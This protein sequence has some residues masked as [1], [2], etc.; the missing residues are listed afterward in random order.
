MEIPTP[1]PPITHPPHVKVCG[2][3]RFADVALA[4][5]LGASFLGL[6][7]AR[8]SKRRIDPAAAKDLVTRCRGELG[9]GLRFVGVFVDEAVDVVSGLYHDLD[10][11]AVQVH[12]DTDALVDSIPRE[13][14]LPAVG[15]STKDDAARLDSYPIGFGPIVAD[16]AVKGQSGGTGQL[17]DHRLVARFLG[18][19]PIL[20]AG[21][22]NPGNITD[23][24]EALRGG[25]LPYGFD[26]SSGIEEAPGVKSAEKMRGFFRAYHDAFGGGG[27][28]A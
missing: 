1:F 25:P 5:E 16:A 8:I 13:R 27:Q 28:G 22:L 19:R 21:G 24:L 18:E 15:I 7:F 17:F 10:L 4:H 20:L 6:I 9:P 11:F 14:I 3:T 2:L 26:L 23:V 12:G